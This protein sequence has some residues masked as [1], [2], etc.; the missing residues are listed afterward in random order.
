MYALFF[1]VAPA[2]HLKLGD[3]SFYFNAWKQNNV[4]DNT[5]PLTSPPTPQDRTIR[6]PTRYLRRQPT[7]ALSLSVYL[8]AGRKF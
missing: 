6:N 4:H 1:S 3:F 8:Y 5:N 7:C 2:T